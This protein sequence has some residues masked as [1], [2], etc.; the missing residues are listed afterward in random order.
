MPALGTN[1]DNFLIIRKF[2]TRIFRFRQCLLTLSVDPDSALN[3]IDN[4]RAFTMV[5]Q[6]LAVI[7]SIEPFH[8]LQLYW[9]LFIKVEN[10]LIEIFLTPRKLN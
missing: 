6:V 9:F 10:Q 4:R 1:H 7:A 3:C 2:K 8:S 5:E